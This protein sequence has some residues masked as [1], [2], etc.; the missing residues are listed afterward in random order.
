MATKLE[1]S[2]FLPQYLRDALE[3]QEDQARQRL[4]QQQVQLQLEVQQ[5][6]LDAQTIQEQKASIDRLTAQLAQQRTLVQPTTQFATV[7]AVLSRLRALAEEDWNA[8][9]DC[10][11]N[12]QADR[13]WDLDDGNWD[14]APHA[15]QADRAL[16]LDDGKLDEQPEDDAHSWNPD[17]PDPNTPT[18]MTHAGGEGGWDDDWD[19]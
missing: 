5:R 9:E 18:Y 14:E 19:S 11:Y 8:H 16:D 10:D 3:Q 13:A 7:L 6:L 1:M 2:Q 15:Q 17:A 12:E 4:T